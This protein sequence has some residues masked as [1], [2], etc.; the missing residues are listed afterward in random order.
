MEELSTW[1]RSKPEANGGNPR[2]CWLRGSPRVSTSATAA[3]MAAKSKSEGTLACSFF[4]SREDPGLNHPRHLALAIA[5]GLASYS[6]DFQKLIDCIILSRPQLLSAP[7]KEQFFHLVTQPLLQQNRRGDSVAP[8]V[9]INGLDECTEAKDQRHVLSVVASAAETGIPLRFLICSQPNDHLWDHFD[10]LPYA[11]FLRVDGDAAADRVRD[12][13][14]TRLRRLQSTNRSQQT[15]LPRPWPSNREVEALVERAMGETELAYTLVRFLEY[16][17]SPQKQ[18]EEFLKRPRSALRNVPRTSLSTPLNL[19]YAHIVGSTIGQY[20]PGERS[21]DILI[22]IAT[23]RAAGSTKT[24][25]LPRHLITR[26]FLELLWDDVTIADKLH[27]LRSCLFEMPGGEIKAY[28]SSFFQYL[29]LMPGESLGEHYVS[30]FGRW[31]KCLSKM[32]MRLKVEPL[33]YRNDTLDALLLGW[34]A[35]C[36]H[37]NEGSS[38]MCAMTTGFPMLLNISIR[39]SWTAPSSVGWISGKPER[40]G[41]FVLFKQIESITPWMKQ[42]SSPRGKQYVAHLL[43]TLMGLKTGFCIIPPP[44]FEGSR[45]RRLRWIIMQIAGCRWRCAVTEEAWS[46]LK[47][48]P[49]IGRLSIIDSSNHCKTCREGKVPSAHNIA[50]H[51]RVDIREW[52]ASIAKDL[53]QE[54]RRTQSTG[55]ANNL[56]HSSL[57]SM[58]L[59]GIWKPDSYDRRQYP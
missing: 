10:N 57:L 1:A 37:L 9:V 48:K 29:V 49:A 5:H 26:D 12:I 3:L 16:H 36:F 54:Y 53:R 45:D 20:G 55:A 22:S 23:L 56:T 28:H 2:V 42:I 41:I 38:F 58:C 43:S 17:P 25:L 59:Q 47:S 14:T 52:C 35:F 21:L 50:N 51:Y 30:L 32:D 44:D 8:L 34:P 13:F 33:R 19:L 11:K 7:M 6:E 40:T 27:R 31:L 24:T 4:F 15:P 39:M 46:S 18:L